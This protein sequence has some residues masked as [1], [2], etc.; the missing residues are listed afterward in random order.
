ML[1]Q[2]YGSHDRREGKSSYEEDDSF[3]CN[4]FQLSHLT[5]GCTENNQIGQHYNNLQ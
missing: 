1:S 3:M 5:A 4:W 2:N